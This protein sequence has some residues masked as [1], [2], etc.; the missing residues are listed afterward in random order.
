[1]KSKEQEFVRRWGNTPM[2]S[3]HHSH[4]SHELCAFMSLNSKL[5]RKFFFDFNSTIQ[6]SPN[7]IY[8]F[9]AIEKS[10]TIKYLIFPPT[11][12]IMKH[13][14]HRL[15]CLFLFIFQFNRFLQYNMTLC[16]RQAIHAAYDMRHFMLCVTQRHEKI[17]QHDEIS[18]RSII[19]TNEDVKQD[20]CL[21][22]VCWSFS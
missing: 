7:Q 4:K 20:F 15:F 2:S 19:S 9:D 13:L 17:S 16:E 11:N 12:S 22:F 8:N 14:A 1:M 18:V 21:L 6:N 5:H 3:H 10:C